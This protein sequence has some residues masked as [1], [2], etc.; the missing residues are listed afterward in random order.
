MVVSPPPDISKG[1]PYLDCPTG[2]ELAREE[3][4]LERW[5]LLVE[6]ISKR[7]MGGRKSAGKVKM[8]EDAKSMQM[9]KKDLEDAQYSPD[10][11][12]QVLSS[13]VE[14]PKSSL[15]DKEESSM[16]DPD[17]GIFSPDQVREEETFS[18]DDLFY[19]VDCKP[20][21]KGRKYKRK[22]WVSMV[23]P[24]GP[25]RLGRLRTSCQ[26]DLSYFANLEAES[27]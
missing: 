5:A 12:Q 26:R 17:E 15:A 7:K 6:A 23:P 20:L 21:K 14:L 8:E 16:D 3:A 2:D 18:M 9:L 11:I 4:A 24:G 10:A 25:R 22:D 27:G 19:E 13:E 1:F